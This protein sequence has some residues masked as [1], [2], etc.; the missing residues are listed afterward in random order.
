MFVFSFQSCLVGIVV[1][2]PEVMPEWAKKKGILG[3]YKDLCKNTVGGMFL[4]CFEVLSITKILNNTMENNLPL[5]QQEL[6]KAILEDLVRLGKA[7]GLHSFE[8]V[9]RQIYVWVEG[10]TKIIFGLPFDFISII[11][12]LKATE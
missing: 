11:L 10:K 3:T 6:K 5:C 2:D 4:E 8:Q 7:S 1:P 9:G 12:F